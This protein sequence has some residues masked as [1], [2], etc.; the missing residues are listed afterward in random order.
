MYLVNFTPLPT[1]QQCKQRDEQHPISHSLHAEPHGS[2]WLRLHILRVELTF[3][4]CLQIISDYFVY[5]MNKVPC[6]VLV[7]E[8]SQC[9]SESIIRWLMNNKNIIKRLTAGE[10][11]TN[12]NSAVC[13]WTKCIFESIFLWLWKSMMLFT[14]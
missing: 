1:Q 10:S 12:Y 3:T 2:I 8:D 13:L 7:F 14:C 5:L 9:L 11:E 4:L 6:L